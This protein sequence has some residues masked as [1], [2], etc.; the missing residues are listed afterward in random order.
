MKNYSPAKPFVYNATVKLTTPLKSTE[1]ADLQ[2]K[3]QNQLDDSLVVKWVAKGLGKE[4]LKNPVTFDTV[5]AVKSVEYLHDLLKAQG[6]MKGTVSW[7]SSLSIHKDSRHGNQQRVTVKFDVNSGNPLMVDTVGYALRDSTLQSLALGNEKDKRISKGDIYSKEKVAMELDR[8]LTLYRNNG[9]LRISK[10]DLY[11]EVDTIVSALIDPS[12]DPFEQLELLKE[13]QQR[14]ENPKIDVM[15]LQRGDKNPLHLQQYRIRKVMIY[16][17]QTLAIDTTGSIPDTT[18]VNGIQVISYKPVFK[19]LFLTNYNYLKPGDLYRQK[20]V[21]RTNNVMNQLGAWQ[22]VSVELFP[23][24]SVSGVDIAIRMYPAKKQNLS[25]D[26]EASLNASDVVNTSSLFG[27]GLNFGLRNRNVAKQSIQSTTNMRFGIELG[28][29]TQLIQTIQISAGQS[30]VFPK[31]ITPFRIRNERELI[32]SKTTVNVNGSYTDRRDFYAV[33]SLNGSIGYEW[34]NKKNR[35]WQYVPLNVEFTRV[36][37]TD[38]LLKLYDSIPNLIYS[39]ND[40]LIISQRLS[41]FNRWV[42][43]NRVLSLRLQAEESGAIFGNIR[44][45]DEQGNLFRFI[46]ADADIRYYINRKKSAWAFR[47][48][49][50]GGLPYGKQIDSTGKVINET[51]LPFFKAYFAGG[52]NSMRAWRVRQ[53]GPGSS[54][55]F[56]DNQTDRFADIQLETN[57]EYRFDLGSVFGIRLKSALFTD[58]GNIWYRNNQGNK[59]LDGAVFSFKNLYKDIAI[60]GGTSLRLDFSY[61]LIRFDWAY[62]LKDPFFSEYNN[63]WFYGLELF[64]G[65]FQLGINYPF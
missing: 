16:P 19:P 46:K 25:V 61:F 23:V 11:A 40:G 53:L 44:Q 36:F 7:D 41:V 6:F 50:G 43:G 22:Q 63:G 17:D 30:F 3:L 14:R 65:Q 42:K 39:V 13:V 10:E 64:K 56:A 37:P 49:I 15:F 24:D 33:Q 54:K 20:E 2:S 47:F 26:L 29:N 1:R 52:P 57:I 34:V 62:K 4:I 31:F 55:I 18:I 12:I 58:I 45:W 60:A 59:E 8:L 27:I 51:N 35:A 9:F 5:Y 48:F 38:S 32:S 28:T 21:F